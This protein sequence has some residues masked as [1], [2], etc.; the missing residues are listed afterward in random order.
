MSELNFSVFNRQVSVEIKSFSLQAPVLIV[1]H[2]HAPIWKYNDSKTKF[3]N[4]LL[5]TVS[6]FV[7]G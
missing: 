4:E 1:N 5:Q 7:K 3:G 2:S 6:E